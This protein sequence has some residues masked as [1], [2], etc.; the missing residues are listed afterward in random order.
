MYRFAAL[1]ILALALSGCGRNLSPEESR[2]LLQQ[3]QTA[4]RTA[5]LDGQLTTSVRVRDQILRSNGHMRRGPGITV[6]QYLT[7]RF[8][9]WRVVEQDGMVWRVSPEGKPTASSAGADPGMRVRLSPDLHVRYDGPA[10]AARRR[11]A[12]R[13]TI[14][15]QGSEEARLEL[16]VDTATSYP[17]RF[18]RHGSDGRL[19]SSTV[20]R[21]VDFAAAP[22]PRLAVPAVATP[23]GPGARADRATAATEQQLVALLGGPLLKPTYLPQGFRPRG[24]FMHNLGQ[25]KTAEIRYFDGLRN[26]AVMQARRPEKALGERGAAR[27]GP[28]AGRHG[29]GGRWGF[30]QR[31][32]PQ[33]K[34]S[35]EAQRA[36]AAAGGVRHSM[37]RGNVIRER[38]GDRVVIIAGD[39]PAE[40]L[41]KVMSSIP[42]P[43]GQRPAVKF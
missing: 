12:A 26:L 13:Y 5:T 10:L 32:H 23:A 43:A 29:T 11:R 19:A 33:A 1:I 28:G 3:V 40:E 17:L 9:G 15:P 4:R 34:R 30:W 38:R 27:G 22:P 36:R 8:A 14:R 35:A 42:Y 7:G 21:H 18:E 16:T 41:Q 20:Y 2:A 6:V 39:L 24:L 25:R 37:W 31:L